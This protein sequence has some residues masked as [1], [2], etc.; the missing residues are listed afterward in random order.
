MTL[1]ASNL[2]LSHAAEL[3]GDLLLFELDADR[4]ARLQEP[5]VAAALA[6]LGIE[7]PAA[8]ATDAAELDELAADFFALFL[9]PDPG[10]PP[11]QSVWDTGS[12]EGEPAA[13]IRRHAKAAGLDFDRLGARGSAVDHLG[14]ILQLWADANRHTAGA[15]TAE[16]L[17]THHLEWGQRALASAADHDGFYGQIARAAS[18]LIGEIV[19]GGPPGN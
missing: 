1:D 19:A 12:F 16:H 14:S 11:V 9:Q 13:C 10:A 15:D 17:R 18:A 4:L 5:E 7:V 6:S 2:E 8:G 3:F